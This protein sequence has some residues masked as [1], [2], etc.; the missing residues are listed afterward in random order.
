MHF[1]PAYDWTKALLGAE[2]RLS[3]I[4]GRLYPNAE[5]T[6]VLCLT[7]RNSED[8]FA[9]L[10]SG[11]VSSFTNVLRLEP[12]SLLGSLPN[13]RP[14]VIVAGRQIPTKERLELCALG[15][16]GKSPEGLSLEDAYDWVI[17][18]NGLAVLN[19]SL[20]KWTG[21]RKNIVRNF[22]ESSKRERLVLGDTLMRPAGASEPELFSVGRAKGYP[23]LA[24][25]DP[26]PI[27]GEEGKIGKYVVASEKKLAEDAPWSS[28][29][30]VLQDSAAFQIAGKREGLFSLLSRSLKFRIAKV[31]K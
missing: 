16:S 30:D 2:A 26:L 28:L 18:E 9:L 21:S 13:G 7:E 12:V 6:T 1:Y 8:A 31:A 23:I 11:K 19:W 4:G 17:Q 3:A 25:S 14:L 15:V 10:A 5:L 29:S 27:S 24:G 22:L 20:G